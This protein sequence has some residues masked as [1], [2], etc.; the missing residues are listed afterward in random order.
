MKKI[1]KTILLLILII[2]SHLSIFW[3]PVLGRKET[4]TAVAIA[5]ATI[6][7]YNPNSN[8]GGG[9]SLE[10]GYF[11]EWLEACIKFDL[12]DKPAKTRKAE[13]RLDFWYIEATTTVEIYDISSS[14]NE[15]TITWNN[16]PY[17]GEFLGEFTVYQDG[18]YIIE[19]TD[20]IEFEAGQWSICLTAEEQN[21]LMLSSRESFGDPP[22]IVFTYEVSDLPIIIGVLVVIG[23]VAAIAI[24]GYTYTKKQKLRKE[25]ISPV[26]PQKATP[27]Q[28]VKEI[29]GAKKY[30]PMCGTPNPREAAY[31]INCGEKFPEL[32]NYKNQDIL[33]NL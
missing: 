24:G 2:F 33:K 29:P 26:V 8:Y 4:K 9:I 15:Y 5:D 6:D 31:C 14:W 18:I 12:S 27:E 19:I 20:I 1:E 30:C 7:Q 3:V 23:I 22:K 32:D 11:L 16:A 17:Y 10:I 28:V 13:L 25:A 21:W